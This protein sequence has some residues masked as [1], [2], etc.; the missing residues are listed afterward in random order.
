MPR[1]S[2]DNNFEDFQHSE[3]MMDDILKEPVPLE[4]NE[5]ACEAIAEELKGAQVNDL[6]KKY[7]QLYNKAGFAVKY[8]PH[9]KCILICMGN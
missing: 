2:P 9:T 3:E 5:Q 1:I 8:L 7:V 4:M 6:N